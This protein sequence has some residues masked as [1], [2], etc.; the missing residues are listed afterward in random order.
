MV[1]CVECG[2]LAVRCQD[3]SLGEVGEQARIL[4]DT[5][6]HAKDPLFLC[7]ARRIR[8]TQNFRSGDC[9]NQFEEDR[10]C[11]SF[12]QWDPGLSPK[13]HKEMRATQAM[14]DAQAA[15]LEAQAAR[16]REWRVAD[17]ELATDNL[18]AARGNVAA[19][20]LATTV[21]L[22]VAICGCGLWVWNAWH[23][24]P[25]PPIVV[26]VQSP[27]ATNLQPVNPP[28]ATTSADRPIYRT[29][30]RDYQGQHIELVLCQ[31]QKLG[32]PRLDSS[33]IHDLSGSAQPE[34]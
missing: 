34:N 19:Q 8:F 17:M 10:L 30:R 32:W 14:L 2:L 29:A 9:R 6:S 31:S 33:E 20:W 15:R 16:E 22:L 3:G 12:I 18:K 13:E 24:S 23:P 1:K 25:L 27:P 5:P 26:Q 7:S 4:V 28:A 11:Q 21:A